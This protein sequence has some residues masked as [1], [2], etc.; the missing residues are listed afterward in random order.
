MSGTLQNE[1]LCLSVKDDG[2]GIEPDALARI[3]QMFSQIDGASTRSESGLGIGLALVKGLLELHGGSIE[4]HS[5]G[6]GHGSEFCVRLPLGTRASPALQKRDLDAP[7]AGP[8]A[9]RVM[10]A[11]DNKDAADA[12]GMLLDLAAHEIRVAYS[13][14][15]ALTLARTFRPDV[16]FIDIG[17]PDL[18]GYEVAQELRR[19]P[20]AAG[21]CLVALTGWGQDDDR[22]RAKDAGFDQ[23]MTKPVDPDAL[24]RLLAEPVLR[25]VN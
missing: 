8:P 18:S 1:T 16:A 5:R 25:K 2:I 19:E 4:A 12:L 9:R 6:T 10:I 23:H 20:W 17:M 3:F 7:P 13:G 24:E 15:S 14:R 22:Q 11:D 21:I